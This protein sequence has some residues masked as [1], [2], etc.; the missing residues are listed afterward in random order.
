MEAKERL[1]ILA[2]F[3]KAVNAAYDAAKEELE[4]GMDA[5]DRK[6]LTVN[7]EKSGSASLTEG[8]NKVSVHDPKALKEWCEDNGILYTISLPSSYWGKGG[9]LTID[10]NNLVTSDGEIVP[11]VYVEKGEPYLSI[12]GCEPEKV[13]PMVTPELFLEAISEDRRLHD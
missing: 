11:G 5:G 9:F 1:P 4:Q 12:K 3:K 8:R 2:A 7:G 13:L 6:T 10:G